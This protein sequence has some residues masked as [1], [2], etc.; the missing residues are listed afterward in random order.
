MEQEI[1][2]LDPA[3]IAAERIRFRYWEYDDLDFVF[4]MNSDREV[5]RFFPA[6]MTKEESRVFI[7]RVRDRYEEDPFSWYAAELKS[8]GEVIGMLGLAVPRFQA[9]FTPCTEVGWRLIPRFWG[10]GLATEGAR[11]LIRAAFDVAG[12]ESVYS[13][14]ACVNKPSEKVMIRSGMTKVGEFDHPKIMDDSVLKR[15]VLYRIDKR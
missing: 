7:E 2:R 13:F 5:M 6:V 3:E 12:S 14:T 4:R 1:V 11:A 15:H 8:T 9:D 10:M